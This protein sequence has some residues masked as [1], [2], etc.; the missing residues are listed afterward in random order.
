[1]RQLLA[2]AVIALMTWRAEAG[3]LHAR[4]VRATGEAVAADQRLSDIEPALKKRFGYDHYQQM[5]VQ[6]VSLDGKDQQRLDL[7]EGFV[8]FVTPKSVEK[9]M[10][11]ISLEWYSGRVA[12]VKTT[13]RI[14]GKNPLF[15]KGP[16]VG[17]DWILL[18]L[19][20]RE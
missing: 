12:L 19:T 6:Q 8:L 9:N 5:G 16:E 14:S 3:T 11:E 13:A 1:M 4:L 15:I 17:K 2:I 20:V 7:G 18:A 10:H